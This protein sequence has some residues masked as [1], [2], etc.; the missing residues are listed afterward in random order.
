MKTMAT[1]STGS[2]TQCPQ[3]LSSA[4]MDGYCTHQ[5]WHPFPDGYLKGT[6]VP[7]CT[8]A[9]VDYVIRANRSHTPKAR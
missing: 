9:N 1:K 8:K 6:T 7:L 4:C 3:P 5:P 2:T